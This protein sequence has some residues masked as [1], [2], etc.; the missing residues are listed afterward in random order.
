MSDENKLSL[1]DRL[2]AIPYTGAISDIMDEMGFTNQV[3]PHS[4]QAIQRGQTLVGRAMTVQG[5][6]VA[7]IDPEV[8]FIPFLKMLGDLRPGDVIVNQ[9]NDNMCA[10]IGELSCETAQFRGARGAV[11]DGGARDTDYILKLGFPVFS[12][13]TT[14][15]DIVGRWRVVDYNVRIKIGSVAIQPGDYVSGDRDGVIIIPQTIAEE[16]VR[17]VRLVPFKV[18]KASVKVARPRF[19]NHLDAGPAHASVFSLVGGKL[20]L[21]FADGLQTGHRGRTLLVA[22]IV[23]GNAVGC[24]AQRSGP[25]AVDAEIA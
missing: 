22:R 9:P 8:V 13:Y 20:D 10:H 12:R 3:L 16:V 24:D 17:V 11:I 5:E 2:A 4:I 1:V 7:S 19:T 18:A 15:L 14:P 25:A 23:V 6:L 21:N